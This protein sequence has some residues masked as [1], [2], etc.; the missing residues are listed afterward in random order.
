MKFGIIAF[1]AAAM[2]VAAAPAYAGAVNGIDVATVKYTSTKCKAPA[3]PGLLV[4]A[5]KSRKALSNA[6]AAHNEYN[7]AL[8][9]YQTCRIEELN[10]DQQSFFAQLKAEIEPLITKSNETSAALVAKDKTT[11]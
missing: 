10:A 8:Q 4:S 2:A 11:K 1:A 9:T 7:D 6:A 3:D 5:I